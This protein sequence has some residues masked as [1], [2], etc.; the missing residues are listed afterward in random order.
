MASS[1]RRTAGIEAAPLQDEI[2][3][4]HGPSNKFCVLNRTSSFIWSQ[5][6]EP[7]TS[8]GIAAR[9]GAS[10]KG[11]TPSEAMSD[12]DAALKEMLALGLIVGVEAG[13]GQSAER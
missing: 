7:A 2:I 8:E 3:L 1:F 6:A 13:V 4:F 5:L 9:M 11:V 12:V 10:F